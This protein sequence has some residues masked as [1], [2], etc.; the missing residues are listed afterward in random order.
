MAKRPVTW[1]D[2]RGRLEYR[3][4]G[5]LY[6]RIT[7]PSGSGGGGISDGDKGDITVASSGTVWTIDDQ[8]VQLDDLS[9]ASGGS[10]LL[11]RRDASG[12]SWEEI[13]LGA[14]LS[15]S[16]SVLSSSGGS[17]LSQAQV[18]SRASLRA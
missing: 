11:G 2:Q 9:N 8:A 1:D 6:T 14:G 18:L 17:G 3:T 10:R 5:D 16:G 12:G 15:I 7:L 4:D 13:T